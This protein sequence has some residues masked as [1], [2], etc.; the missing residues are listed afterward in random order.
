MEKGEDPPT[1]FYFTDKTQPVGPTILVRSNF[2]HNKNN[3]T[4][5]TYYFLT[6]NV[7]GIP[8]RIQTVQSIPVIGNEPLVSSFTDFSYHEEDEIN[9]IKSGRE[10]YGEIFDVILNQNSTFLISQFIPG[11]AKLKSSVVARTSTSFSSSSRFVVSVNNSTILTHTISNVGVSYTDDFARTSALNALFNA[12]S[13]DLTL[14]YTFQPYNAAST[15]WLDYIAINATRGL[16]MTGNELLFQDLDTNNQPG[17]RRYVVGNV[18]N[19]LK[20]WSLRDHN[21]VT[22]Q[23]YALNNGNPGIHSIH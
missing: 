13:S 23:Q 21:T 9:F 14:D 19:D 5:T 10:W 15:G 4:D 1:I 17:N 20:L 7:P 11:T 18:K 8:K 3:F 22:N 12:T 2:V 16:S 6:T